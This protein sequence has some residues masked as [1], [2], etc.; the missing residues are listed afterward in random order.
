MI[1]N[2]VHKSPGNTTNVD[3]DKGRLTKVE[4]NEITAYLFWSN[5][6]FI[7]SIQHGKIQELW[8]DMSTYQVH[9]QEWF[10]GQQTNAP[11]SGLRSTT[12]RTIFLEKQN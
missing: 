7:N 2:A 3:K 1:P 10:V 4:E 8:L 9:T 11:A 6:I 12:T 5:T